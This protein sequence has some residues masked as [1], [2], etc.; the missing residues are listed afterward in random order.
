MEHSE[1]VIVISGFIRMFTYIFEV[2]SGLPVRL[3]FAT[4]G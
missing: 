1:F 4:V 3:I 2:L